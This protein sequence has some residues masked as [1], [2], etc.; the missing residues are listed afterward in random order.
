MEGCKDAA[1]VPAQVAA[2]LACQDDSNAQ[3]P[4]VLPTLQES[5][6]V[7]NYLTKLNELL[8]E[9]PCC[10]CQELC[11]ATTV[12]VYDT[13]PNMELL[14]AG[15]NPAKDYP[16]QDIVNGY[17]LER[18]AVTKDE[19]SGTTRYMCCNPCYASL[20]RNV[21]PGPA[22]ANGNAF[23]TIP[24]C[25]LALNRDA[26]V[27][28]RLLVSPYRTKMNIILLAP[29]SGP[30][31]SQRAIKGHAIVVPH[32]L[33]ALID[34][35]LPITLD[36][37]CSQLSVV[38]VRD[39]YPTDAQFGK[40]FACPRA[41][42]EE[43]LF[44][45]L[46][47]HTVEGSAYVSAT[48]D[49]DRLAALPLQKNTVPEQ[50]RKCVTVI[51]DSAAFDAAHTS[52]A[53]GLHGT[54]IQV[55]EE[56]LPREPVPDT[57]VTEPIWVDA[58]AYVDTS[59][60]SAWAKDRR[61]AGLKQFLANVQGGQ[62]QPM[63]LVV[64]HGKDLISDFGNPVLWTD[65]NV[66]LFPY[67]RGGAEGARKTPL[68]FHRWFKHCMRLV[69]PRFRHDMSFVFLATNVYLRRQAL[70]SVHLSMRYSD[71]QHLER[72]FGGLT[73]AEVEQALSQVDSDSSYASL[74][75]VDPAVR[76]K[77]SFILKKVQATM[78]TLRFSDALKKRY[79]Q[80]ITA[81]FLRY[82]L[83]LLWLTINPSDTHMKAFIKLARI[84]EN[85]IDDFVSSL[86]QAQSVAANPARAAQ[87]FA[88]VCE[89]LCSSLLPVFGN[90][91][92]HYGVVE[93]QGRGTLH[94][95]MLVWV[96]GYTTVTKLHEQ[97]SDS[98]FKESFI[99]YLDNIISA[100]VPSVS[101]DVKPVQFQ[102]AA[103]AS[104]PPQRRDPV[105]PST[106][107]A[108]Q[109]NAVL[110]DLV[111]KV[112]MHS[113][114]HHPSCFKKPGSTECRYRYPRVCTPGTTID[115]DGVVT[116]SR[117][118]EYLASY[119]PSLLLA[120]NSNNNVDCIAGAK[121][122]K[123]L[124]FYML[125]YSTKS[126]VLARELYTVVGK[127]LQRLEAA[128][129]AG[130]APPDMAQD[131][132]RKC[133]MG[134]ISR[135]QICAS[136]AALFLL[137][138]PDH[139]TSDTF[140]TLPIHVFVRWFKKVTKD[141]KLEANASDADGDDDDDAGDVD[142]DDDDLGHGTLGISDGNSVTQAG[143]LEHYLMRPRELAA[144]SLFDYVA[145]VSFGPVHPD[146]PHSATALRFLAQHV[147]HKTLVCRVRRTAVVPNATYLPP[148]KDADP[149]HFAMW[150][151]LM[152]K[153]FR[154][155]HDLVRPKQTCADAFAV[156]TTTIRPAAQ[157]I[158]SNLE[159]MHF[160]MNAKQQLDQDRHGGAGDDGLD[161]L[162]RLVRAG[163]GGGDDSDN[164]DAFTSRAQ[165]A[166]GGQQP[167]TFLNHSV[168]AFSSSS[169]KRDAFVDGAL[170]AL[171]GVPPLS[172]HA[173][174]DDD[175]GPF[176]SSGAT[177]RDILQ[178]SAAVK[179]TAKALEKA[180][181]TAAETGTRPASQRDELPPVTTS[182]PLH[183]ATTLKSFLVS[184]QPSPN[185]DQRRALTL[186]G[187]HILQTSAGLRPPPMRFYIGGPAG[188]GKSMILHA[189]KLLFESLGRERE[190]RICA[191]TGS[192]ALIVGGTTAHSLVNIAINLEN[193]DMRDMSEVED[194]LALV[195]YI[196]IDE[197]S[198]IGAVLL[199]RLHKRLCAAKHTDPTTSLFGNVNMIFAGDFAQLPP[200]G[201]T[202]LYSVPR[203]GASGTV[204]RKPAALAHLG[205]TIWRQLTHVLFLRVIV[206]Q[207]DPVFQSLLQA[208]RNGTPS[209]RDEALL[210]SRILGP[211]CDN[212]FITAQI[213]VA[214]NNVRYALTHERA[215]LLATSLRTRLVY[216][217]PQ[218][219]VKRSSG[220]MA[221]HLRA[222]LL[223]LAEN[224]TGEMPGMLPLIRNARYVLTSKP[225]GSNGPLFGAVKSAECILVAVHP[226]PAEPAMPSYDVDPSPYS[227]TQTPLCIVVRL[228]HPP[229]DFRVGG[230]GL[231]ELPLFPHKK[232][233]KV[234][235]RRLQPG[236]T[237]Q[238]ENPEF[239]LQ[240]T[241]FALAFAEV[242]V[243]F[244]CQGHTNDSNIVDLRRPAD[245][246]LPHGYAY[247]ALSRVRT[248]E[249][250]A[251]LT[252]FDVSAITGTIPPDL[253]LHTTF[254]ETLCTTTIRKLPDVDPIDEIVFST[255]A[256]KHVTWRAFAG[257]DDR[258][259]H[260]LHL[261]SIQRLI[262]NE[263]L[264]HQHPPLRK[265]PH[266]AS[267]TKR[268]GSEHGGRREE[269]TRKRPR[270]QTDFT[271]DQD[272]VR[273]FLL[274]DT[275]LF[276]FPQS[277]DCHT[278]GSDIWSILSHYAADHIWNIQ[279][280]FQTIQLTWAQLAKI[281]D[282]QGGEVDDVVM[283][284]ASIIAE[285]ELPHTSNMIVLP[286]QVVTAVSLQSNDNLDLVQQYAR[287]RGVNLSTAVHI[288]Y[289][290]HDPHRGH[291][292]VVHIDRSRRGI[293]IYDS[294]PLAGDVHIVYQYHIRA[295]R[296][297][298]PTA[299][300]FRVHLA[301]GRQCVQHDGRSC[302]LYAALHLHSLTAVHRLAPPSTFTGKARLARAG[303]LLDILRCASCTPACATCN[304]QDI[305]AAL[306]HTL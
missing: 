110:R 264:L 8:T 17:L 273:R 267:G 174:V 257:P 179:Q 240:R 164:E 150:N 84:D 287:A 170:D 27:V 79:R 279:S 152:H 230:L 173:D 95:H 91:K 250:L 271:G 118:A 190:F 158:L 22:I 43:A 270:V 123:A 232:S 198:L 5:P 263:K 147:Q 51:E 183:G 9:R 289:I 184:L 81:L 195:N 67:G 206:R 275:G 72:K 296:S 193:D 226:H 85:F 40:M 276:A 34:Q 77:L 96:S 92:A 254:L 1:E 23:G 204:I 135:T 187:R 223:H 238:G 236:V 178:L 117:N 47:H 188:T 182:A 19:T 265:T 93:C 80:E 65:T 171:K 229:Q 86:Q 98:A 194:D 132:L 304:R 148:S 269:E 274:A 50:I 157:R 100:C 30:G 101:D 175:T 55:K 10:V 282:G 78:S 207:G 12:K 14:T 284:A 56:D 285:R 69:D 124:A 210:K 260:D 288:A 239:L 295:A 108:Q 252:D 46:K 168:D 57:D 58:S 49:N 113:K 53:D 61:S 256:T 21:L 180:S 202:P 128:T 280:D 25:L 189:V 219:R 176:D 39:K 38:F 208:V 272:A 130:D 24:E 286:S 305:R 66:T 243:V 109:T 224:H 277:W 76:A 6:H 129:A 60:S 102:D 216:C 3:F 297:I 268:P 20:K 291:W 294:L 75:K 106:L 74:Q 302:G 218:D 64:P 68:S 90:I 200:V 41:V 134:M 62:E 121:D 32:D 201:E 136:E 191:F 127:S 133:A 155:V 111:L 266:G 137:D 290:A 45:L 107:T 212:R 153:P 141:V 87:L 89:S 11:Q 26:P 228:C 248:L 119:N 255:L 122:A 28:G 281:C 149:E 244:K 293:T 283:L 44:W 59:G 142:A 2:L 166:S 116:L 177:A 125:A 251:I 29:A 259:L 163:D 261:A 214:R 97:L 82:G 209:A 203:P 71:F 301:T 192:A 215:L 83:P 88:A 105:D 138:L 99:C 213:I 227:L 303:L 159:E 242:I 225:K 151:L 278:R 185:H 205:V 140:V 199:A 104:L 298:V 217:L 139:Y 249:G 120:T 162:R 126:S 145:T 48:I 156:F 15:P 146:S 246:A 35:V 241:Q 4:P 247:T 36:D 37:V 306:L 220:P 231:N 258:A 16:G 292:V 70:L 18:S 165:N 143:L 94:M 160:G 237:L 186:I 300:S 54:G 73:A 13:L 161:E 115:D 103:D 42:I 234:T 114:S 63:V 52:Y 172:Q 221:A 299:S 169:F 144:L 131:L 33:P 245:G 233:F 253:Q 262:N 222:R 167:G 31:T 181:A 235:L 154:N 211:G 197:L 7:T 112:Q 196:F